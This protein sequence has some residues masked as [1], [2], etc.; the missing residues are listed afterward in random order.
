MTYDILCVTSLAKPRWS[1]GQTRWTGE[2][3][4]A[5]ARYT[6]RKGGQRKVRSYFDQSCGSIRPQLCSVLPCT[7]LWPYSNKVY[8]VLATALKKMGNASPKTGVS[9]RFPSN[10][11]SHLN[12]VKTQHTSPAI[13]RMDIVPV[14]A[15]TRNNETDTTQYHRFWHVGFSTVLLRFSHRLNHLATVHV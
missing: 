1:G 9:G 15:F 6:I 5:S 10:T 7:L 8:L 14:H 3:R 13:G 2:L 12:Q 11:D 4:V